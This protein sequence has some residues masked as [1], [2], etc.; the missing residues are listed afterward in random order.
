M[1]KLRSFV[2]FHHNIRL[3]NTSKENSLNKQRLL[4]SIH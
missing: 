3:A 4:K 2:L 1:N